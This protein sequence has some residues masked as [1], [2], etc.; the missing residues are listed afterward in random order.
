MY[1]LAISDN[2]C[3]LSLTVP[4]RFLNKSNSCFTSSVILKL[5]ILSQAS[6]TSII[7]ITSFC[8]LYGCGTNL[9]VIKY[10]LPLSN[11]FFRTYAVNSM[12]AI[13]LAVASNKSVTLHW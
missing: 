4:S 5:V 10:F 3:T 13:S 1:A 7:I 12:V 8:P 9:Y 11:L 2:V 6:S